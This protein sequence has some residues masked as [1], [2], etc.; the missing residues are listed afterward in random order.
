VRLGFRTFASLVLC[1]AAAAAAAAHLA[2]DIVGDYALEH[3]AYDDIAH[4]SRELVTAIA[5]LFAAVLAAR[6]LQACFRMAA[7]HRNRIAPSR[8]RRREWAGFLFGVTALSAATVPAMEYLDGR[9]AGTPIRSI[10]AAFGGSLLL[11]IGT[12]TLCALLVGTAIYALVR[13]LIGHRDAITTIIATLLRAD[14]SGARPSSR[15]LVRQRFTPRR[16]RPAH[17]LQLCKRG[18]PG[19]ASP[20]AY[21]L[22]TSIKGDSREFRIS[23]RV[24]SDRGVRGGIGVRGAR[25]GGAAPNR[26]PR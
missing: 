26:T 1:A 25:F 5:L 9:L 15:D 3:D 6:G 11:G 2:I 20:H 8:P 13:W 17:A 23:S 14:G 10:D 12:T 4:G 24:A 19:N 7:A 16:R 18:P 21:H 22:H